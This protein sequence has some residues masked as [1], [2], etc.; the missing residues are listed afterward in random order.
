MAGIE[1][2]GQVVRAANKVL[3]ERTCAGHRRHMKLAAFDS[4]DDAMCRL[5]KE[6][7]RKAKAA[8]AKR[9]QIVGGV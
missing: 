7:Q 4:P 5:C 1:L 2:R 3:G 8:I 9:S 6:R